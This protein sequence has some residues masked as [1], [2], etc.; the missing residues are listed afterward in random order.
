[1]ASGRKVLVVSTCFVLLL[2]FFDFVSYA[3]VVSNSH[4][5]QS[6]NNGTIEIWYGGNQHFGFP[7][8][9]QTSVNIVG[10]VKGHD[11]VVSLTYSINDGP[12]QGLNIGP[13]GRRLSAP[14]DFNI[15]IGTESLHPGDN[16]VNIIRT[17]NNGK[18]DNLSVN[19]HYQVKQWPLPYRV[20]WSEVKNIQE[21]VQVVDGYWQLTDTGVRT[22][23]DRQGY[24]RA[25]VIGDRFWKNYEILLPF[26]IHSIDTSAYTSQQS[27]RPGLGVIM[28]WNGHTDTPVRCGQPHCGWFPVGAINWYGFTKDGPAGVNINTRPV[29]DLTVAL[30]YEVELGMQYLLRCQVKK[31]GLKWRYF[32]KIWRQD[33]KEPA[34]WSMVKSAG[35]KNPDHG[36]ILLLAHHLDLSLGDIA[37]HPVVVQINQPLKEYLHLLPLLVTLIMGCLFLYVV[38]KRKRFKDKKALFLVTFL[39]VVTVGYSYLEHLLPDVLVRFPMSVKSVTALY[40]GYDFCYFIFLAMVWFVVIHNLL[41]KKLME[42]R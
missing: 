5:G 31:Q 11:R 41:G 29:N 3:T 42:K 12:V 20:N 8:V 35:Q 34:G 6:F 15:E 18:T 9:G 23:S 10:H 21:A 22:V 14:G 13:D 24:D 1:M 4:S 25:L 27:V 37:V 36:G 26:K 39:L 16:K 38:G 40:L 30:P 2:C 33:E 7:G 32:L 28:H 17:L 19:L